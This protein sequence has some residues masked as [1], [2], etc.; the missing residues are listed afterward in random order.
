MVFFEEAFWQ[1]VVSELFATF[2]GAVLGIL[3]ALWLER[4]LELRRD[5]M[6]SE[7]QKNFIKLENKKILGF[8]KIEIEKNVNLMIQI[9]NE[10]NPNTLIFY[11][12]D[13]SAWNSLES[14]KTELIDNIELLIRLNQLYYEYQH[15]IRKVDFHLQSSYSTLLA[16]SNYPKLRDPLVYSIW[17]HIEP[18]IKL[19][20][21][22]L[23]TIDEELS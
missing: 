15:I 5:K 4:K 16:M 22:I 11:N 23:H 9:R 17:N 18:T 2:I 10:F 20:N 14:K 3:T 12:L 13:V 19:S 6:Y 1:N 8:L 21:E 7:K